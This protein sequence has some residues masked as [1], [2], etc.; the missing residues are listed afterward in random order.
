MAR[1][2][3]SSYQATL[4]LVD[5]RTILGRRSSCAKEA[6]CAGAKT[7]HR[8]G[9][10]LKIVPSKQCSPVIA[11]LLFPQAHRVCAVAGDRSIL[12][13]KQRAS[14]AG[15]VCARWTCGSRHWGRS[16]AVELFWSRQTGRLTAPQTMQSSTQCP[17]LHQ[18][19]IPTKAN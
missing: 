14:K 11:V 10:I 7:S 6:P 12:R 9:S 8:K 15:G 13:R 18:A 1:G 4:S 5:R 3:R 17:A 19:T 16:L 2:L